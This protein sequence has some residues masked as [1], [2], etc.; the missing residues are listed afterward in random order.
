MSTTRQQYNSPYLLQLL[1]ITFHYNPSVYILVMANIN[2]HDIVS[3][4]ENY[5]NR[6]VTAIFR[7]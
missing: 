5:E 3:T 7:Q 6:T 4:I 1:N 2:I